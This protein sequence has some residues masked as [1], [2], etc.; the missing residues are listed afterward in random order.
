MSNRYVGAAESE[1]LLL[2]LMSNTYLA[3]I[4][5]RI[6]VEVMKGGVEVFFSRAAAA[7]FPHSI[8]TRAKVDPK[9][10]GLLAGKRIHDEVEHIVHMALQSYYT[11]GL[12]VFKVPKA[13][14]L[15]TEDGHLRMPHVVSPGL[16]NIYC[17]TEVDGLMNYYYVPT[18]DMD[19]VT[20][21]EE[22]LT[23]SVLSYARDSEFYVY[24]P[25]GHG[26]I[27]GKQTN[28]VV[29]MLRPLLEETDRLRHNMLVADVQNS[30]PVVILHPRDPPDGEPRSEL[31][32]QRAVLAQIDGSGIAPAYSASRYQPLRYQDLTPGTS[33]SDEERR[34]LD[35][36]RGGGGD[37][38]RAVEDREDFQSIPELVEVNRARATTAFVSTGP[39]HQ[40]AAQPRP[41]APVANLRERE[42]MLEDHIAGAFGFPVSLFSGR[43]ESGRVTDRQLEMD[44]A[45]LQH[46]VE[47]VRRV[48]IGLFQE[49]ICMLERS[50]EM[51]RPSLAGVKKLEDDPTL[52]QSSLVDEQT[53]R[54]G[55]HLSSIREALGVPRVETEGQAL[56]NFGR[57]SRDQYGR[58]PNT[59]RARSKQR[60]A[61]GDLLRRVAGADACD[62][63]EPMLTLHFVPIWMT[64]VGMMRRVAELN[65]M[66]PEEFRANAR[67]AMGMPPEEAE[68][69]D[70]F[71]EDDGKT[72]DGFEQPPPSP[73]PAAETT[74]ETI[75]S[76]EGPAKK[77][78]RSNSM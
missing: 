1:L 50:P 34:D 54:A 33:K 21:G 75:D 25:L 14:Q 58:A 76:A 31:P 73:P 4:F 60:R 23:R 47:N 40:L 53:Q 39:S 13:E 19:R 7:R 44:A 15:V 61:L 71:A 28:S 17:I 5:K 59:V 49:M 67:R 37:L 11:T 35:L 68:D 56:G 43:T 20:N 29:R 27:G 64:D 62:G 70:L 10:G 30:M 16:G 9:T 63:Q 12:I 74:A 46:S 6:V 52:V 8:E 48:L 77:R 72:R 65:V 66:A 41:A 32:L 18:T 42:R 57:G 78:R 38:T 55:Q 45:L 69:D 51:T 3:P 36:A 24:E 22:S 26:M 2:M